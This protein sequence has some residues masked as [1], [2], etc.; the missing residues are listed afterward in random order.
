MMV[1]VETWSRALVEKAWACLSMVIIVP[2]VKVEAI[3]KMLNMI[4]VLKMMLV[5][6]W[7][8]AHLEVLLLYLVQSQGIRYS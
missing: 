7:P 2:L 8:A 5:L 6:G 3:I 4:K 1:M